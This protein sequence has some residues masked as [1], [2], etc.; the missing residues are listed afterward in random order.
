[1]LG[2]DGATFRGGLG[3]PIV[4]ETKEATEP[5]APYFTS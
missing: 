4:R 3:Q 2:C 5:A 1:M